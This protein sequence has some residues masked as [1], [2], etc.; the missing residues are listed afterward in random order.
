MEL[1]ATI[2]DKLIWPI[3]T[4]VALLILRSPLSELVV[5]LK[6]LKYKELE[7]EFEREAK[8]I[9]AEA[10]R[11]LPERIENESIK[12][13]D[14]EPPAYS[15]VAPPPAEGVLKSWNYI[16]QKIFQIAENNNI[17]L[18]ARKSLGKAIDALVGR[19]VFDPAAAKVFLELATLRNK[20]AHS[21]KEAISSE[22]AL[23][24]SKAA[25]RAKVYFETF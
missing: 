7:L 25:N 3:T 24:F 1:I 9:L 18:G 11:D 12:V 4:I 20:V 5:T 15:R 19:N 16:E 10:E 23:L 14:N 17:D 6:K 13:T 8:Q 21:N 22:V 2:L